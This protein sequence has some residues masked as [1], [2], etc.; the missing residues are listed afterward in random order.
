MKIQAM[1][2]PPTLLVFFHVATCC[3]FFAFSMRVIE[4]RFDRQCSLQHDRIPT[5]ARYC[6]NNEEHEMSLM[7]IF[8]LIYYLSSVEKG[9]HHHQQ[10]LCSL[11][12]VL[13]CQKKRMV[14]F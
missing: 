14:D 8:L 13:P 2:Q 1:V 12:D 10:R 11:V 6:E 9:N 5:V 4:F 7:M 3:V